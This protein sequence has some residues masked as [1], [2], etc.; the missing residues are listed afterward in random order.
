MRDEHPAGWRVFVGGELASAHDNKPARGGI[1]RRGR[2]LHHTS[3]V[4][5][6]YAASKRSLTT[7][8]LRAWVMSLY[9][10]ERASSD[11]ARAA[12]A[13][14]SADEFNLGV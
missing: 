9:N 5:N 4:V 13:F 6:L 11:L 7:P 8:V 2:A 3:T 12:V 1:G 14:S 10:D